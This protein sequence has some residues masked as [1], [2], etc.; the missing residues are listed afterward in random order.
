[1]S[2]AHAAKAPESAT[3]ANHFNGFIVCSPWSGF[4]RLPIVIAQLP[5]ACWR[6]GQVPVTL[7]PGWYRLRNE[8]VKVKMGPVLN[9]RMKCVFLAASAFV[10]SVILTI[11]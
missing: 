4:G 2:L 10:A 3:T 6:S 7:I 11:E 8:A 1:M 9:S 5:V